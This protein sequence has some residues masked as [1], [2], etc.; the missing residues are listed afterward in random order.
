MQNSFLFQLQKIHPELNLISSY[1]GTRNKVIVQDKLGIQ[2]S[3]YPL[4]L[5][6]G[7]FPSIQSALNKTEA[8][9]K[10]LI[11]KN[12]NYEVLTEYKTSDSLIQI[13][14]TDNFIFNVKPRKL[15]EGITLNLNSAINYYENMIEKMNETHNYNYNYFNLEGDNSK[16]QLSIECKKHGIFKQRLDVHL[17]G[18]KCPICS[19][20][21]QP[22]FTFNNW[23]DLAIKSNKFDSYKVY[24]LEFYNDNEKF[25]KIGRTFT[26]IENR[27]K[28]IPYNINIISLSISENPKYLYDLENYFHRIHKSYKYKPLIKFGGHTECYSE[29]LIN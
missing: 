25:Y 10:L 8:F 17:N 2:Y 3:V 18:G 21:L 5:L 24:I 1:L 14:N 20:S 11:S 27:F 19:K 22:S 29:I 23:K 4:N 7:N 9:Q 15:L 13:K 26:S 12:L 16:A 28:N 6:K